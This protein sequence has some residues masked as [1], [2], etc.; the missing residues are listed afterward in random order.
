MIG[1]FFLFLFLFCFV[2]CFFVFVFAVHRYRDD[3]HSEVYFEH[4]RTNIF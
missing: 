3:Q 1:C 2:F 4:P